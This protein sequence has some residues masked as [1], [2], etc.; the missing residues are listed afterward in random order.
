ML[1]F[2]FFHVFFFFF[3]FYFLFFLLFLFSFCLFWITCQTFSAASLLQAA[4]ESRYCRM[5]SQSLKESVEG[6][7]SFTTL[8]A[9]S[10][11]L[12]AGE[13]AISAGGAVWLAALARYWSQPS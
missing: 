11:G 4:P 1:F 8:Q 7:F 2:Y 5:Y 9:T 13:M 6:S 10:C 12:G 3:L